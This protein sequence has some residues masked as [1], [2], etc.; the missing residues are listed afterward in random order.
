MVEV[1]DVIYIKSRRKTFAVLRC[2]CGVIK[3]ALKENVKRGHH[4][5]CGCNRHIAVTKHGIF[6]NKVRNKRPRSYTIWDNLLRRSNPNSVQANRSGIYKTLLNNGKNVSE[7]WREYSNFLRDM[8]EPPTKFHSIDRIDNNCGYSKE[9]CRWATQK[10]QSRNRSN[11]VRFIL[12]GEVLVQTDLFEKCG[13]NKN[14]HMIFT[15]ANIAKKRKLLKLKE[16]DAFKA[17][18]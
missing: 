5:S 17:I 8:G 15:K 16:S 13:Y 11:N 12:N 2:D 7:E 4:N 14:N 18:K 6:K 10:E 3:N 9:N 1:I